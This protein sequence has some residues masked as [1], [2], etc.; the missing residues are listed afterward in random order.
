MSFLQGHAESLSVEPSRR[1]IERYKNEYNLYQSKYGAVHDI[2][3][4]TKFAVMNE[5]IVN[6]SS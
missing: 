1:T 4:V 6:R 3:N 5:V 2:C